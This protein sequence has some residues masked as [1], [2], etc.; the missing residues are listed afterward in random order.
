VRQASVFQSRK[1][2]Q[3]ADPA[4]PEFGVENARMILGRD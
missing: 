1:V 3:V 2:R 4:T